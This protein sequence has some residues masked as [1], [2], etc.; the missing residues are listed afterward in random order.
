[1]RGKSLLAGRIRVLEALGHGGQGAVFRGEMVGPQG[2]TRAV[3]IKRLTNSAPGADRTDALLDEARLASAI[4]HPNVVQTLDVVEDDD[5]Y[6]IVMELVDGFSLAKLMR[7]PRPIPPL[8]AAGIIEG[9]LRGLDAAHE[10][11]SARGEPLRIVH[12]DFSPQNILVDRFGTAKVLDF[13]IA[14]AA[15]RA[16]PMT[17]AGAFKGKVPY[18]APEQVHGEGDRRV[19]LWAAGVVLWEAILARRLFKRDTP[20]DTIAAIMRQPIEEPARVDPSL[21][22]AL[23]DVA[24]RALQRPPEDRYATA[25]QMADALAAAGAASPREIA[26]WI[27]PWF[28]PKAHEGAAPTK[29]L[30]T[31]A[32][33]QDPQEPTR[34]ARGVLSDP[35]DVPS[36]LGASLGA[37]APSTVRGPAAD[38]A[39]IE[40][41]P[42]EASVLDGRSGPP[43]N[44][45]GDEAAGFLRPA[46]V[47]STIAEDTHSE[48]AE[49]LPGSDVYASV[50]G[51]PRPEATVSMPGAVM[52]RPR[53]VAF[54][55][56]AAALCVAAFVTYQRLDRRPPPAIEAR[57]EPALTA[58]A[59]EAEAPTATKPA[60]EVD[61]QAELESEAPRAAEAELEEQTEPPPRRRTTR[62]RRARTKR[63]QKPRAAEPE[64]D[65][66]QPYV[67][68]DGVK[69]W[70]REC[71]SEE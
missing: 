69:I 13:G 23:S 45:R 63:R 24:V 62:K 17:R 26:E 21:P 43:G 29:E 36:G 38:T 31:I 56:A 50:V 14:K 52:T 1:M 46:V 59:V 15:Q 71:F 65:C 7:A 44:A 22:T 68:R 20:A 4:H 27:A 49:D 64:I 19:D 54:A 3:A 39:L 35:F 8:V 5:E 30:G 70:R 55:L 60:P 48:S 51:P 6:V 18:A 12:R 2:F 37:A 40:A 25:Q 41:A 61:T 57:P 58:P 34:A 32:D 33:P 66:S 10:A 67:V 53:R 11:T 42:T 16:Q 47:A 9:A 28:A